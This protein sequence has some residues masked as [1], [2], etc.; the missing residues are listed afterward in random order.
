MNPEP[1]AWRVLNVLRGGRVV[2]HCGVTFRPATREDSHKIAELFRIASGGVAEYVWSTLAPEYPGLTPLEIGERRYAREE[3]AFSYNNCTVAELGGE[4]IG[5][6]HAFPMEHQ[7]EQEEADEL[8][9]PVLQPYARLEVPGSYYISA[10]AVYLEHRGKGQGAQM[11]KIAKDKARQSGCSEV[12][13]LVFEQNE[14]AIKL[15]EHNGFR[16][17]DRAPVVPHESIRYSGEVLLMT[18]PV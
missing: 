9:D 16:V 7:P 2:M 12:S 13:L 1:M 8:V 14:G 17:I 15:Y 10:M 3:G 18:A 5:M 6:L 11:L 4:V